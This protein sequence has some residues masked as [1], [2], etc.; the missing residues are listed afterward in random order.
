MNSRLLLSMREQGKGKE[1]SQSL[2]SLCRS[3]ESERPLNKL[4]SE[5]FMVDTYGQVH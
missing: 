4:P 2:H 3:R 5:K 1:T